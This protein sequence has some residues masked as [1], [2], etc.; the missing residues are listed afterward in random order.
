MP[1]PN[2]TWTVALDG[3]TTNTR[4]RL[5]CGS[6]LVAVA[7]RPV[8][9][10]DAVLSSGS[11]PL[12][13]A[14]RAALEDVGRQAGGIVPDRIVAAGMLTAEVGLC[15]V[16]HVPAPAGLDELARGVV[17]RVLPKVADRPI[18]FIPGVRTPPGDGPDGWA[19][20]DVMRGEECETL[21]ALRA[22]GLAGPAA[23]VWPG[24]HTK[25]VAVDADGRIARSHT[26]LAGELTA[27]LARH[28]LLAASL[29][30]DWPDEPDPEALAAGSRLAE[31]DG[32]GRA[33]FLVRIADLTRSLPD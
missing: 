13:A 22:L 14:V 21:G 15:P 29:P 3:G 23:F 1:A 25:L 27:A 6:R 9:V 10:R 8:G 19:E 31:R 7:R 2:P 24:S 17:L 26:T 20:A 12:A 5:L 11:G 4:A 28:T 30:A 33:A 18:A 16:P 32:L